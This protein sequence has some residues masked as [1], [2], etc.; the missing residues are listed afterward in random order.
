MLPL[1]YCSATAKWVG[2][3]T[4]TSAFGT[5]RHHALARHLALLAAD[6]RLELRIAFQFLVFLLDLLLASCAG[7]V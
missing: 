2:L 6:A 3:V 5:S 1:S 4:T 7:S